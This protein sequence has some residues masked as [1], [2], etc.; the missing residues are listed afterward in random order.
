MRQEERN[1]IKTLC[2]AGAGILCAGLLYAWILIP[3]GIVIPCPFRL[4]TGHLCPGCG[5]TRMCLAFLRG[6]IA[7]AYSYNKGLFLILPLIAGLVGVALYRY[8]R[9]LGQKGRLWKIE[10][11]MAI[12]LIIYLLLWGVV[13]NLYGM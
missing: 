8:V 7:A 3:M 11:G 9:G 2:K 10:Q 5:V 6:D 12:G 1:R 4:V 13:R